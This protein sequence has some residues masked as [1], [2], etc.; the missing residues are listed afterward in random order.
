MRLSHNLHIRGTIISKLTKVMTPVFRKI[1]GSIVILIRKILILKGSFATCKIIRHHMSAFSAAAVMRK[2]KPGS[3][4]A[5][6]Y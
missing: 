3:T 5:W 6:V 1:T 4:T 2:R